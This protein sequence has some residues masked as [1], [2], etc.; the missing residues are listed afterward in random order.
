MLNDKQFIE[1]IRQSVIDTIDEW[2]SI[3]LFQ[4]EQLFRKKFKA[5]FV[6]R[7]TQEKTKVVSPI[8][9]SIFLEKMV[10]K[11]SLFKVNEVIGSDYI[12]KDVPIECKITFGKSG[13]TGNGYKK[14][15]FHLLMKFDID[16]DGKISLCY[17]G[18]LNMEVCESSWSVP[19]KFVNFSNLKLWNEDVNRIVNIIG[20]VSKKQKYLKVEMEN[21]YE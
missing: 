2:N 7:H 21:L 10:Q 4:F 5:Y 20:G 15:P 12:Y 17:V 16:V 9:D 14:T 11:T 1:N 3:S 6:D 13:W 8:L 18:M 19:T